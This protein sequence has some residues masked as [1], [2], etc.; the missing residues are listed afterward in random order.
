MSKFLVY[1][2]ADIQCKD[3]EAWCAFHPDCSNEDVKIAC[4]KHC[5]TCQGYFQDAM[6]VYTVNSKKI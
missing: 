1:L 4:P 2:L 3:K 6:S 5:S